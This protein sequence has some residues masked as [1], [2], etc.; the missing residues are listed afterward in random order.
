MV[1]MPFPRA[2]EPEYHE[3]REDDDREERGEESRATDDEKRFP[4]A[5]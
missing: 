1:D 3:W 5:P 4:R 2:R